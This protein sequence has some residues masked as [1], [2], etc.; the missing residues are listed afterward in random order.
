MCLFKEKWPEGVPVCLQSAKLTF[1]LRLKIVRVDWIRHH[2]PRLMLRY[3]SAAL[4]STNVTVLRDLSLYTTL[5]S[6]SC[7]AICLYIYIYIHIY[8]HIYT[9]IYIYIHVRRCVCICINTGVCIYTYLNVYNLYIYIY[10]YRQTDRQT[11]MSV[12]IISMNSDMRICSC[13]TAAATTATVLLLGPWIILWKL[14]Y[15]V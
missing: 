10:I 1:K 7:E 8:I 6:D 2:P 3:L 12:Y 9:Y 14:V 4:S 11:D 5:F 15:Y 13:N